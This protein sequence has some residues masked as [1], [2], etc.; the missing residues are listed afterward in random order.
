[1]NTLT[2][3]FL[4]LVC[5]VIFSVSHAWA[6]D[7]LVMGVH[8]YKPATELYKIFK[9]IA[10]YLS[11]KT[12]KTVDLQIAQSYEDAAEKAGNGKFDLSYMGPTVYAKESKHLQLKPLVQIINNGK[13]SFHG[14]IIVKQGSGL[15]SL[16]QLKGKSFVFGEKNSTLTH[17]VPLYLL[18]NEG[19]HLRDLTK[20]AFVGSHDNV[21]LNVKTGSFDA[22]GLMPDI[23][24]KYKDQGIEIIAKSPELPEHVFVATKSMD[25]ATFNR[26]Q[27]TLLTMDLATLKGIKPTLTGTQKVNDKDFDIL[28]TIMQMVEKE[29]DRKD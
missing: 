5:I 18:L 17:V 9:P 14:V 20:H 25:A 22:G 10:D 21:A 23:A 7:T 6:K 19:I 4:A 8:P 1:M 28:R 3:R 11:Q 29:M 2:S 26:I 12:G 27:E 13:P 15:K 16:K 24:E